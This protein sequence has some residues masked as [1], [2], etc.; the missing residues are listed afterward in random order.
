M[1]S[2]GAWPAWPGEVSAGA[3]LRRFGEATLARAR[4]YAA[5]GH[6]TS[7]TAAGDGFLVLALV[8]GTAPSDYQVL[9][10][11]LSDPGEELAF[12]ARC[13][14]PV[15]ADCKHA[16][17]VLLTVRDRVAPPQRAWRE[18]LEP[19]LAGSD[20]GG[21]VA[22]GGASVAGR[23][24][25]VV[26]EVRGA[27]AQWGRPRSAQ[28]SILGVR[29]SRAG[30]WSRSTSWDMVSAGYPTPV[31]P[32]HRALAAELVRLR[33]AL[34]TDHSYA[35]G[36]PRLDLLGP[37]GWDWL[38]RARAAGV[39]VV[40]QSGRGPELFLEPL[41][42]VLEVTRSAGGI[43]VTPRL[44]D[45]DVSTVEAVGD[46]PSGVVLRRPGPDGPRLGLRPLALRDPAAYPLLSGGPLTVP[47]TEVG[48]FLADYLPGLARVIAV[49]SPDGSVDVDAR[50][51]PRLQLR[52]GP[53]RAGDRPIIIVR[54]GVVYALP[55]ELADASAQL[56]RLH[57]TR[58]GRRDLAE[59]TD[60]IERVEHDLDTR[61]RD[62]THLE[63]GSAV[64]FLERVLPLALASPDVDVLLDEGI[65]EFT[66]AEGEPVISISVSDDSG[67]R[68]DWFDLQVVVTID[69]EQVPVI[70]LLTALRCG[71]QMMVLPSGRWFSLDQPA[72]RELRELIEEGRQIV[73]R[74]A[75]TL[76]VHRFDVAW[77]EELAGLGVIESQCAA[78]ERQVSALAGVDVETPVEVPSSLRAELRPY[79]ADGFRWLC[80]IWDAGL[81]GILAD[82]MGLGKTVQTLAMLERARVAGQL[83]EPVLVVAPTSVMGTWASE[84]E[85][86][87]P[88]LRVVTAGRT[89]AKR[90]TSVAELA[91]G[92]DLVITSYAVLRLDAERFREVAWRAVLLDEAHMVKNHQSK[93]YLAVRR[94]VR[95]VTIALTGTPV[96]NGLM[97]LWSLLSLTAPGLYPRPDEFKRDW[98]KPIEAGDGDRLA[99]LRRRIR[100]LM[101]RRTKD[102]VALDLP[103]KQVQVL[104]IELA[105]AHRRI[106]DRHFQRERQ[107]VLGLL[108][109]PEANRVE[110]LASLTRLRQLALD[111]AL[112]DPD[113]PAAPSAKIETVLGQ[114]EELAQEGHRALVFS[115]FTRFLGRVRERLEAAG[116]ATCYLDGSTRRRGEVIEEFR[117]GDAPVFLISLKAGGVGLTLTEADYV[118]VL[119]PWWNR[120]AESQAIDRAHRIGQD[121]PVMVYRL[122]STGTIEDK[123]V[124]LQERK[125]DL[126]ARVVDDDPLTG[127]LTADDLRSLLE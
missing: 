86:F 85:R 32:R 97:D 100:P 19:V 69:G 38:R 127:G 96:E 105:P 95:P 25:G 27:P 3:L 29:E 108:E 110:I 30:L 61:L 4:V 125:R 81:G 49:T 119:D 50:P 78:W 104:P 99:L 123:V 74:P 53:D 106:Y 55:G 93:T 1:E 82:D 113:G 9:L 47:A 67:G 72:L 22:G 76:S 68:Q 45:L 15:R 98:R 101:L 7:V 20:G 94:L 36:T 66:E 44:G 109:D 58:P 41:E 8:A 111:V 54:W 39:E 114:I 16:A 10:Q 107:R 88:G 28:V 23:R 6:V 83:T 17:A 59:E 92:A 70:E 37:V 14:C 87:A 80:A 126:F 52:V 62:E 24:L 77:F 89:S 40:D 122:V 35:G 18:A 102:E 5:G 118:F 11:R 31:E 48:G 43:T 84:A 51:V 120:A 26:L 46:P 21:A 103:P 75:G 2:T 12:S 60:L 64:H 33:D 56:L 63:G 79:Q 65:P 71:D 124:A 42:P 91:E 121:K 73:D 90:R 57:P 34:Q 116:V 13:S 115:Q 117:S 112:V